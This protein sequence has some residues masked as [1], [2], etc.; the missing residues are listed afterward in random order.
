[1]RTFYIWNIDFMVKVVPQSKIGQYKFYV[2]LKFSVTSLFRLRDVSDA[3]LRFLSVEQ[4]LADTAHFI[5]HIQT[6]VPGAVNSQF[7]LVGGHY[8]ASL[9]VWFRQS[10]PHLALG[11]SYLW[12]LS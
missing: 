1:M 3:N 10:Y 5:N 6:T 4:A 2:F 11:N 7:I 12:F 9:A 8:S